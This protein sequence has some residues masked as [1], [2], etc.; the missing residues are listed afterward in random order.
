ME[1]S[2][3]NLIRL[4]NPVYTVY[5]LTEEECQ[6]HYTEVVMYVRYS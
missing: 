1:G 5:I 2:Y 6:K 3:I 4:A